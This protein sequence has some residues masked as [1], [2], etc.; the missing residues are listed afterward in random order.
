MR[1]IERIVIPPLTDEE[2]ERGL[3]VVADLR[4]LR[5]D[6]LKRRGHQPYPSSSELLNQVRDDRTRDLMHG[7]E[8]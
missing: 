4:R 7:V 6:D 1:E 8:E 3:Q 5:E 2:K